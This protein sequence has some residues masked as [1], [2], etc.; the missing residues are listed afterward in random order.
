[1]MTGDDDAMTIKM[2]VNEMIR[3]DMCMFV[4]TLAGMV[5]QAFT[6]SVYDF[7]QFFLA[8]L[9]PEIQRKDLSNAIKIIIYLS[10]VQTTTHRLASRRLN[11]KY[12]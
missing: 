9:C 8:T 3:C 1:M 2:V 11:R 10:I 4:I 12:T 7:Q 5:F 6:L